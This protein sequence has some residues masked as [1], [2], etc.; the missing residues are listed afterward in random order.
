MIDLRFAANT[1]DL[2]EDVSQHITA[3]VPE[4]ASFAIFALGILAAF[5]FRNF[6][7]QDGQ[8]A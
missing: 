4:P 2:S 5:G 3:T 6:K 8:T 7:R 1:L